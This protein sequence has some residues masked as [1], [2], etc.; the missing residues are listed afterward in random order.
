MASNES[1]VPSAQPGLAPPASQSLP[2]SASFVSSSDSSS[3][4]TSSDKLSELPTASPNRGM[5]SQH[6]RALRRSLDSLPS[7]STGDSGHSPRIS[8]A[9]NTIPAR[10]SPP[11][12]TS[13]SGNDTPKQRVSFDSDRPQGYAVEVA[14]QSRSRA[15]SPL[16][17]FQHLSAGFHRRNG[18][19]PDDPFIPVNPFEFTRL[20]FALCFDVNATASLTADGDAEANDPTKTFFTDTLPRQVYLHLLLR[21]PSM[22]FSRVARIFEDAEVSRPDIERMIDAGIGGD[23]LEMYSPPT[24]SA[25]ESLAMSRTPSGTH[26]PLPFPEEWTPAVVSPALVRFKH[27]WEDFIGSLIKEWKTLNVVSAL[28]L[29]AI[30]TMFQIPPAASDPVTRTTAL[31]SL[32]SALMSL[33]YGCVYIVRFST[34]RSMYR[35]SKFAEEARRTKTLIWWNVWTLLSM[36]AVFLAWSVAFFIMSIMSFVWSTGSVLDPNER[37][38]LGRHAVL[39]PRIAVTVVLLLGLLYFALI[40]G[41]LRRYGELPVRARESDV[42]AQTGRRGRTMERTLPRRNGN[43]KAADPTRSLVEA[44]VEKGGT[45]VVRTPERGPLPSPGTDGNLEKPTEIIQSSSVSQR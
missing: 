34:M 3:R 38:P 25:R 28:L 43:Q 17:I 27:S 26:I 39:G 31:L 18:N 10:K 1:P 9:W 4:L 45:D 8:Q 20:G 21:L 29:S 19:H 32:V 36:P 6:A 22:Y 41:T 7:F 2:I 15:A 13:V 44:D 33:V 30:L 23:S 24:A 12:P 14:S 37:L 5:R 42:E 40:I 16:R 35:A 11:P